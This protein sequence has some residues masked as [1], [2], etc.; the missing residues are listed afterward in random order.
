MLTSRTLLATSIFAVVVGVSIGRPVA[1]QTA[2][3]QSL[4]LTALG[5]ALESLAERVSPAVVQIQVTTYAFDPRPDTLLTREQGS[6]SGVIIAPDGYIVTNAHVVDGAARIQVLL[7]DPAAPDS[8]AQSILPPTGRVVGA[9]L[10]GIDRATDLAVLKIA[11]GGHPNLE[12]A[13]SDELRPGH[14]VLAFGSPLGLQDTVTFGVVSAGARQLQADAPMIYIQTDAS[15]NPGNSGGPLVD[16]TGRVVGINTMIISQSGGNEGIG[17]AAPS[18]IARN[19]VDQIRSAGRVRR[20]TIGVHAQTI[21]TPLAEGL[22]LSRVWGVILGDV[23][24]GGPAAQAGLRPGDIVLS[25]DG[26]PMENGRQLQV[27]LFSRRVGDVVRLEILRSDATFSATVSVVEE[28]DDLG[29]FLA[30]VQPERNLVPEL[31]IV[32][33]DFSRELGS[34]MPAVRD[35]TGVVVAG[36]R[37]ASAGADGLRPGDVIHSM[38]GRGVAD[39]NSLRRMLAELSPYATVVLH[40]ERQGRLR[41]VTMDLH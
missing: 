22:G 24:V 16:M 3:G 26:K 27:N 13:D 11:G 29:S 18:N 28:P 34:M 25:M 23:A 2:N 41:F 40:I 38:N 33:I 5:A 39:L 20:G 8:P 12:W 19:V 36:A 10:V 37:P 15:I 35:R 14:P 4:D 32:A 31:D 6:G 9:Q 7:S 30:R 21:T 17:F 1:A